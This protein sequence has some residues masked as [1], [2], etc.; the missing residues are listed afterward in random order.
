MSV[1]VSI[2][3]PTKEIDEKTKKCIKK[4]EK[5][6]YENFEIIVLPDFLPNEKINCSLKIKIIPTGKVYP[7]IK[8]NI[9]VKNSEGDICAFIDSDAYPNRNWLKNAILQFNK[10]NKILAVGG[11]NLTPENSELLEKMSGLILSS[12]VF[13][14]KFATRHIKYKPYFPVELPSCNL[15]VKK[16]VFENITYF[17][18]QYLTAEDAYLCFKILENGGLIFYSP[19]VIVYHNRRPL[20]LPFL[21]QI[22]NYGRDKSWV[23]KK[24]NIKERFKKLCYY[25]IPSLITIFLILLIFSFFYTPLRKPVLI[26]FSTYFFLILFESIRKGKKYFLILSSGAILTH[27]FY[28]LGFIYGIFKKR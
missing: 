13:M 23:L 9:G 28:Y 5:L 11:P 22:F 8:K 19:D 10:T 3:I 16:E 25:T 2:I 21:K 1:K 6:N 4:C 20:F 18:G 15:F 27:L 17:P 7:S 14:G 26:L 12:F 24:L